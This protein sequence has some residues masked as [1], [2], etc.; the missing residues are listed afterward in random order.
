MITETGQIA[1]VSDGDVWVDCATRSDC[2]RCAE[3]RG[4]GGAV[5]GRVLG[6]RKYRVQVRCENDRPTVGEAVSLQLDETVLLRAALLVYLLPLTG[7]LLGAVAGQVFAGEIMAM[8]GGAVGFGLALT[9]SR[10]LARRYFA[11]M[12]PVARM[13]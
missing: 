10:L 13:R 12:R 2:Q 11:G 9:V 7:L 8:V 1:V 3:G 6:D 5:L 4:C